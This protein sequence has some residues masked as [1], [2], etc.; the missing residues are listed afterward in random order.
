M[1]IQ[2]RERRRTRGTEGER[3]LS[4]G[5][6]IILAASPL[7]SPLPSEVRVLGKSLKPRPIETTPGR[8]ISAE[9]RD[10]PCNE[11]A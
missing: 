10:N 11:Q 2:S 8:I 7:V 5:E 4:G 3:S 1:R 6:F 9:S